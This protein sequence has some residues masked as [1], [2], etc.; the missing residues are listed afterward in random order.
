MAEK[1]TLLPDTMP[2]KYSSDLQKMAIDMEYPDFHLVVQG[3]RLACHKVFLSGRSDFFQ[4]CF[5]S[6][7]K[8][9]SADE[10]KIDDNTSM[11]SSSL[12]Q[13]LNY[14]YT[15]KTDSV[16]DYLGL[17]EAADYFQL[18]DLA[19]WCEVKLCKNITVDN[20]IDC[21]TLCTTNTVLK[22]RRAAILFVV[23]QWENVKQIDEWE[24]FVKL[25]PELTIEIMDEMYTQIK[26][27]VR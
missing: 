6:Q 11:T 4:A 19:N 25:N 1:M 13:I 27:L 22:L 17:Y 3:E 20:V 14:F 10:F 23:D 15:G 26:N 8:E 18:V 2:T 16:E 9:T 24:Q 7:M 5:H 21:L 12:K